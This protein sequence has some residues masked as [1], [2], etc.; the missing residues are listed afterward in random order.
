MVA[1]LVG[2]H[3][4]VAICFAETAGLPAGCLVQ[5]PSGSPASLL[6]N[7]VVK[8][9]HRLVGPGSLGISKDLLAAQNVESPLGGSVW[10]AVFGISIAHLAHGGSL[11][12]AVGFLTPV[13][14]LPNSVVVERGL[15][16][17]LSEHCQVALH[18]P[19]HS[20]Q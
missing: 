4:Q 12:A 7:A 11:D 6:V 9:D 13:H 2:T 14:Q 15:V 10:I 18:Y 17:R 16:L 19:P 8:L 1:D 3:P 20:V 5:R